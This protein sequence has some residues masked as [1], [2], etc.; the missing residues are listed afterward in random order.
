LLNA[1]WRFS[2]FVKVAVEFRGKFVT[3]LPF[4]VTVA[5]I[6]TVVPGAAVS[7]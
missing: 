2:N 6:K 7:L 1:G 5:V 3:L 4:A